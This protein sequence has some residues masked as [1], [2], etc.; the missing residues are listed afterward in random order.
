MWMIEIYML[1]EIYY[2]MIGMQDLSFSLRDCWD[3]LLVL[4]FAF[5]LATYGSGH[6]ELHLLDGPVRYWSATFDT[7]RRVIAHV[8]LMHW[9]WEAGDGLDLNR[10]VARE[11]ISRQ[12]IMRNSGGQRVTN[13][14]DL[15]DNYFK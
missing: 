10:G 11:C 12:N 8:D 3:R 7:V 15:E 1:K 13:E 9:I 14:K 6:G 2:M 5:R 4:A